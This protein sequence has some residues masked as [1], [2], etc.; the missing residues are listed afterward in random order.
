MISS[1]WVDLD[2]VTSGLS[3]CWVRFTSCIGSSFVPVTWLTGQLC[4]LHNAL[5][6]VHL[7][8]RSNLIIL[9]VTSTFQTPLSG[10]PHKN[11]W[12]FLC[13]VPP[14]L[15]KISMMRYQTSFIQQKW[16]VNN[17]MFLTCCLIKRL[18][19]LNSVKCLNF[20]V[21]FCNL[22]KQTCL[23]CED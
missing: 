12:K 21:Y 13:S 11:H 9:Q 10:M 17:W 15:F 23:G 2:G 6:S 14:K 18:R 3:R 20:T 8:T 16:E 7:P 19:A 4:D 22:W 5:D 1:S